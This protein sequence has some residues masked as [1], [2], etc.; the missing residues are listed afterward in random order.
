MFV[1][2]KGAGDLASGV[3]V[4]LHRA[5]IK[6]TM[7]DLTF[8][9]AI[10]HTVSFCPAIVNGEAYVEG[11]R[12]VR[13]NNAEEAFAAMERGEIAVLADP[14]ANIIKE[15][16]PPVVV[17]A[18]LAKY[19]VNTKI[20]DAPVVV[21]MGPGFTAGE[22]CHAVIETM[23]ISEDRIGHTKF[24]RF[25]IHGFNKALAACV[26]VACVAPFGT[27]HHSTN[28]FG[29]SLGSVVAAGHQKRLERF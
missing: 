13:V 27:E 29:N 2:I 19:N 23:R 8:P 22:D 3:A 6:I 25:S 1:V 4:R 15:M 28:R 21:A 7:T 24:S 9:T 14:E 20:T 12:G 10:R 16:Q 26:C 17:D 18:I 11:I 5:G